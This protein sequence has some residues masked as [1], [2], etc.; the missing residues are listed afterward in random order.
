MCV[1]VLEENIAGTRGV[2]PSVLEEEP[3]PLY[4]SGDR[5][6]ILLLGMKLENHHRCAPGACKSPCNWES[7][8]RA[9]ELEGRGRSSSSGPVTW[10]TW[11]FSLSDPNGTGY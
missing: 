1:Q 4:G 9:P 6:G 5:K 3:S 11:F 10:V 7:R 8:N 2:L